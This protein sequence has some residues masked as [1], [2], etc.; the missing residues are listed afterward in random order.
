MP[1]PPD[2]YRVLRVL[3][4]LPFKIWLADRFGHRQLLMA[5]GSDDPA[6]LRHAVL[7]DG[8]PADTLD[9]ISVTGASVT[10]GPADGF[11]ADMVLVKLYNDD[12]AEPSRA[13]EQ[14]QYLVQIG[15]ASGQ[16]RH[17]LSL[18]CR[19][20]AGAS[21]QVTGRSP[22]AFRLARESVS[23]QYRMP[24][25]E[26]VSRSRSCTIVEPRDD[27][28]ASDFEYQAHRAL[29]DMLSIKGGLRKAGEVR[30]MLLRMRPHAGDAEDVALM[31]ID[32]S[33]A[34]SDGGCSFE[35]PEGAPLPVPSRSHSSL[36][37]LR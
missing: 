3:K 1:G 13:V 35:A 15:G 11:A 21:V 2:N 23:L 27:Q 31:A 30:L 37:S 29:A 10:V 4:A 7:L 25:P 8:Q 28:G 17:E 19:F 16:E 20:P 6:H 34:F 12:H 14:M 33:S 32:E 5:P 9:R 26:V 24:D 22:L 18:A 36:R